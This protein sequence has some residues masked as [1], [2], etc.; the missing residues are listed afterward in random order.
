MESP[1]HKDYLSKTFLEEL[2]H[3][4]WSTKGARF[5]AHKRLMNVSDLSTNSLSFLTAYLIILGL[6]SV[7]QVTKPSIISDNAV[8][9][10]STALSILLLVFSQSEAAKDYKVKAHQF[11][12][13]ALKIAELY[14]ELKIYQTLADRTPEKTIEVCSEIGRKYQA[15]LDK[16]PNHESI[17]FNVFKA[18][19]EEFYRIDWFDILKIRFKYYIKYKFRYHFLIV[20]TPLVFI[21]VVYLKIRW[22]TAK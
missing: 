15:V 8:A 14:N 19:N 7:Y 16:Y 1:K 17:D 10:G 13:C 22:N 9:F 2:S 5:H 3:K 21:I 11:H 4:L 20:G 12:D 6:L 18:D